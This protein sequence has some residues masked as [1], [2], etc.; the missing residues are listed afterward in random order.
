MHMTRL[1]GEK[2][3]QSMER[4]SKNQTLK[5]KDIIAEIKRILGKE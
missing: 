3:K 1:K 4:S 5:S 2:E